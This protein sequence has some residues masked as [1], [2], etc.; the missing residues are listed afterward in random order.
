M[1]EPEVGDLALAATVGRSGRAMFRWSACSGCGRERWVI[2]RDSDRQ[3]R[4]CA[5][6]EWAATLDQSPR[7][8]GGEPRLGDTTSGVNLGKVTRAT[9]VWTAC[10]ECGKERWAER[11]NVAKVCMRCAALGRNLTGEQN[12]R[13]KGGVR[14]DKDGYRYLSVPPEHPFIEMAGRVFIHGK[15]RYSIVEHRLVM[16]EH[17]GRPLL[18]WELVHH[19]NGIKGDN[20]IQ[21]LE[22]LQ[23]KKEHL[24]SMSVQRLVG[25]L[26]ARVMLLEAE[27]AL[28]RSQLDGA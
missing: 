9:H 15:Y 25:D 14:T 3:C 8:E 12:P 18:P 7:W 10:P 11:R 26:Q 4:G 2:R 21:N 24:P 1:V 5:A 27:V 20:R 28:L 19:L 13:W 22:L 6:K 17:L 16:A 23:F